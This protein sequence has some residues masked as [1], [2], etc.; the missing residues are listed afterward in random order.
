MGEV[1][2]PVV[3]SPSTLT[4]LRGET[5]MTHL[6][7]LLATARGD[8]PADLVLRGGRV[9]NVFTGEIE[10][11]DVAICDSWIA[12]LG[13][14]IEAKRTIDLQGAFV[15]PG[16]IDAHVHI[17]S[18]MCLPAQFARAIVPRGVTSAVIDPHEIANVCG[19][20]GVRF[21]HDAS[22]NLP[23]DVRVM[24]PSCVP[25]S[26]LGS[27]GASLDC[28]EIQ[29]LFDDGIVHGLAEVMNFPG[30]IG[31]MDSVLDKIRATR[32]R[33]IDG[34]APGVSGRALSAY[35]AAGIGSDHECVTI[36]EARARLRLG[37]YVLIR[38]ATN[39]RN[40]DALLPVITR[41]NSRRICFCTDDRTPGDLL[42]DGSIDMMVRRAIKF[43]IE[44]I[45][46][47]RMATLNTSEW[48][49][50]KDVGAIAPGRLANLM[51][52]D[53]LQSPSAKLVISRGRTVARD[54]K[55]LEADHAGIPILDDVRSRCD[56]A[57][58]NS[59]FEIPARS[60]VIR[61]IETIP[62]QLLTRCITQPA[63]IRDGFAIA[64]VSRDLLKMVVCE[65]HGGSGGVG[66]GFVKG[67]GLERGA[68]AGTVAHDHHNLVIIGADDE[69]MR[70]A[71]RA[72]ISSR[73][74]MVVTDG[75]Q[76]LSELPLPIAGLMSDQPIEIVAEKYDELVRM[77]HHLGSKLADPFMAMSFLALEVIPSC[78]LTDLGLI[79]VESFQIVDL[80]VD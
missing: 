48:F 73:G 29:K 27:S 50:L 33:P 25:A 46:A 18:S 1:G 39:A 74:G 17:E 69:S 47:I 8:Q 12:V 22:R 42:K 78:K 68:I 72:V 35:A 31:G 45:E 54:G 63:L 79:D 51:V 32:A 16:L 11:I 55:M 34:H 66:L 44:P 26:H 75:C 80:F 20:A 6:S 24:A 5:N 9:V 57:C 36:E 7:K 13:S 65:R 4:N 23:L 62:D 76:T 10:A 14:N 53:D 56:V 19:A 38:E 71:A 41:E 37:L 52:F 30:V 40:L 28:G 59:A 3:V 2:I 15:S 64:D 67:I 77:A 60:P 21:M 61:V 58:G 70:A 49:G 43:G